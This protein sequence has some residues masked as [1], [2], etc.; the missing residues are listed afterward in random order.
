MVFYLQICS[1]ELYEKNC[2]KHGYAGDTEL[3]L[4]TDLSEWAFFA[5]GAKSKLDSHGFAK[6]SFED[7]RKALTE[8]NIPEI[9]EEVLNC[10]TV[11]ME[12]TEEMN[13]IVDEFD[14]EDTKDI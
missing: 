14:E 9:T 3:F 6:K 1:L 8:G 10:K 12:A 7:S 13:G 5:H 11:L 4:Q 2:S